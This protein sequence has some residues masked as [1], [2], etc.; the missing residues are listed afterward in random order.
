MKES[1]EI[2]TTETANLKEQ[3]ESLLE[4]VPEEFK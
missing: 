3:L 2:L 1:W 4:M